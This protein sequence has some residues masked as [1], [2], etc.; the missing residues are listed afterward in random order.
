MFQFFS[1]VLLIVFAYPLNHFLLIPRDPLSIKPRE[2]CYN[3][4]VKNSFGGAR[5]LNM[6]ILDLSDL[7][8]YFVT[9]I[10]KN[11]ARCG[12]NLIFIKFIVTMCSINI[13]NMVQKYAINVNTLLLYSI[14]LFPMT[15][16]PVLDY[17]GA[18]FLLGFGMVSWDLS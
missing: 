11:Y 14:M 9:S 6:S 4:P 12:R 3:A 15:D 2:A 1:G 5:Y 13:I 8:P 7:L 16:D 10:S 18:S 17:F